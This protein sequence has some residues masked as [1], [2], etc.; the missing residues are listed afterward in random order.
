MYILQ[1]YSISIKNSFAI[2]ACMLLYTK[3]SSAG[4]SNNANEGAEMGYD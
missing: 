3:Y 4:K 1:N 2:Y